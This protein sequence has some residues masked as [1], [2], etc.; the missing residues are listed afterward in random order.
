MI[1]NS[2]YTEALTI[3][4]FKKKTNSMYK[5]IAMRVTTGFWKQHWKA[6]VRA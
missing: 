6:G 1:V 2:E 4:Y 5:G 3:S